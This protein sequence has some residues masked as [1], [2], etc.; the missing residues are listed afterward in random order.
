MRIGEQETNLGFRVNYSYSVSSSTI[1]AVDQVHKMVDLPFKGEIEVEGESSTEAKNN[2]RGQ[3]EKIIKDAIRIVEKEGEFIN[4]IYN[5][6]IGN[7]IQISDLTEM[8][9]PQYVVNEVEKRYAD[10]QRTRSG[11]SELKY[12][13]PRFVEEVIPLILG[14]VC[15]QQEVALAIDSV[16]ERMEYD[17]PQIVGPDTQH[18]GFAGNAYV[19]NVKT[20]PA[21]DFARDTSALRKSIEKKAE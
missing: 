13:N 1:W 10:L 12:D 18:Y 21:L 19:T 4:V 5:L 3:L 15:N 2:L 8:G 20:H 6:T 7:A 14:V 16:F 9:L 11:S 17:G